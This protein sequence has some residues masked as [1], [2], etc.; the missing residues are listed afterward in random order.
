MHG[1]ME[2]S[3]ATLRLVDWLANRGAHVHPELELFGEHPSRGRGVFALAPIRKGELLLAVPRSAVVCACEES[4][5]SSR[6]L[7]AEARAMSPMVR[8]ALV[9]MREEALGDASSWAPYLSLLPRS[10]DTLE[11]WSP[12]EIERLRGTAVYDHLAGL[13][14]ASGDLV[15]AARLVYDKQIGRVVREHPDLWPDPSLG[16]FL[17]ACA[18]AIDMLNHARAGTATALLVE[19]PPPG[20]VGVVALDDAQLLLCYGFV[21]SPRDAP[22]PA[23]VRLPLRLLLGAAAATRDGAGWEVGAAWEAKAAACG[24]LLE[25]YGGEVSVSEAEPLPDALLTVVQLMLLPADDFAELLRGRSAFCCPCEAA[26]DS[27]ASN[28]VS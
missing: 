16:A 12:V 13:R 17:R 26:A 6:W 20:V 24:R 4:D 22:L 7:P 3:S 2:R 27:V 14:D 1:C 19:R 28:C 5:S 18:A 15:G 8:T 9:L 10:Y 11:N 25:P 23:S 21:S